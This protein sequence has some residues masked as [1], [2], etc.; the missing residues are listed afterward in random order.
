MRMSKIKNC[1]I[2][3]LVIAAVY[4]TGMLWLEE[5]AGRNI[6]YYV[7]EKFTDISSGYDGDVIAIEPSDVI[8]GFGDKKYS[9]S[10]KDENNEIQKLTNTLI[11]KSFKEA[12]FTKK[13]DI[14]WKKILDSKVV[15]YEFPFIVAS[16]EY[17]KGFQIRGTSSISNLTGFNNIA[18]VPSKTQGD[19]VNINFINTESNE[20]YNYV[21]EVDDVSRKLYDS[22]DS[23]KSQDS[24][25]LFYIST[26]QSEF[27]IFKNNVFIPQLPQNQYVYNIL[28]YTNPYE[29]N[30]EV[31]QA[32]LEVS[33][34]PL[35]SN[36]AS[37]Q[38]N[39]TDGVY[40]F[41]NKD[42]VV[43]YYE[44]GV[45]EYYNYNTENQ[46]QQTLATA[47]TVSQ[48]FLKKNIGLSTDLVL[49]N[50]DLKSQGLVFYFDYAINDIGI[51]MS[52]NMKEE[53]GM[54]YAAEVVV[55]DNTVKRFRRLA[56]NFDV[57]SDITSSID[58]D[59]STALSNVMLRLSVGT[60]SAEIEQMSLEYVMNIDG[61]AKLQWLVN[62][63]GSVYTVD[64]YI[65]EQ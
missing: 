22:I 48:N 51:S 11:K 2:I 14:N 8:V 60:T 28:T 46:S 49:K 27:N 6:F 5:S 1:V 40:T 30:D 56:Y 38:S 21:M 20:C 44:N 18:I 43:K 64:S 55:S 45:L 25:G 17:V 16:G 29:N 35:F 24:N 31:N 3:M 32:L 9:K 61:T 34:E 26:K 15:V 4:Q 63:E 10:Y 39:F 12:E 42:T 47:Y 19:K 50:V 7:F 57:N 37:K 33:I 41:S 62:T 58:V 53:T 54:D 65:K 13:S 59:F 23:V 52:E 36:Y